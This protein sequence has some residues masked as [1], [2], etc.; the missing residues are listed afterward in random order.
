[1]ILVTGSEAS[2]KKTYVRSLGF[3]DEEMSYDPYSDAPVILNVERSVFEALRAAE[4]EGLTADERV[5]RTEKAKINEAA[6]LFEQLKD[7]KVVT[8]NEVGSGVIPANRAERIG[9]EASGRLSVL[10]AKE[11]EQV[12]R[13]VCGI[14]IILK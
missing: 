2:G 9:R 7:K 1:M 6:L 14:P 3:T 11:A 5:A 4:E 10:L 8:I 13:M 12:V